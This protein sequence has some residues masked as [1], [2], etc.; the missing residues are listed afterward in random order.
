MDEEEVPDF[1]NVFGKSTASDKGEHSRKHK[2]KKESAQP[3]IV[4]HHAL[5]KMFFPKFDG[6]KPKVWIDNCTTYFLIYNVP[7][8]IWVSSAS[9]HLEGN[10]ASWWQAFKLQHKKI[11]WVSFC[12]TIEK[13]FGADYRRS[14]RAT[15][16]KLVAW[17]IP[18]L[19][20]DVRHPLRV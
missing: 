11:G 6:T 18:I 9:M 15:L 4:P 13:Q 3:E 17:R 10:A 16:V 20:V 14:R 5:P 8:S 1:H 19:R 12:V 2:G 7:A